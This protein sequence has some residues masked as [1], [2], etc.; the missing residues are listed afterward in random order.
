MAVQARNSPHSNCI[1]LTSIFATVVLVCP[2]YGLIFL[3]PSP[4]NTESTGR[5]ITA[6]F[7]KV[8]V[9]SRSPKEPLLY[10]HRT[11]NPQF[12]R[13]VAFILPI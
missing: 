6:G 8:E 13:N 1:G 4:V 3:L 7:K 10:G 9:S 5:L 12:L 11:G 2:A